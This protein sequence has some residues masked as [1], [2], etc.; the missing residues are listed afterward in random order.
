V[1]GDKTAIV[2][3]GRTAFYRRG[4]SLPQTRMELGAKAVLA[5]LDDAG[6]TIRDVDGFA[7]YAVHHGLDISNLAGMLGIPEVTFSAGVTGGGNGFTGSLI[8]AADAITSGTASVVV[9]VKALQQSEGSRIGQGI[10]GYGGSGGAGSDF[11]RPYGQIAPGH[12]YALRAQRHMHLYGTQRKHFGRI[13]VQQRA[14]ANRRPGALFR[15]TP[16]TMEDYFNA[17]M[18]NDPF[19]LFDYCLEM[20]GAAALVVTSAERA[21]DLKQRPVHLMAAAQGGGMSPI[22]PDEVS[23]WAGQRRNAQRLFEM[24][25]VGPKDIDVAEMYDHFTAMVLL[26]LEDFGF[27][28]VGES[29][30]F[31]EAGHTAWPDGA[32]PVNTHGGNLSDAYIM[33]LTHAIEAVEQLRGTAVNQ[34]AGAEL[35]LV[36][37]APA[38]VPQSALI[39]SR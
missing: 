2:G 36:S 1:I 35:A 8:L 24:A 5:A 34:V 18:L 39:L 15:D 17:R 20:D 28:A 25:G 29:G 13:A 27:C 22:M 23:G 16:M 3:V 26:Q 37:G 10:G 32:I 30:A 33:G 14:N 11:S 38:S 7:Q 4:Q 12:G 19:C 6:L 9:C 31:V 21:R